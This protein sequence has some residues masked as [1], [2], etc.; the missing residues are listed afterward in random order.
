MFSVAL[1]YGRDNSLKY[2]VYMQIHFYCGNVNKAAT[3]NLLL[4][5]WLK[6]P[7]PARFFLS[8]YGY[9]Y[10]LW[11]TGEFP[12]N[13]ASG[14]LEKP[15]ALAATS[16]QGRFDIFIQKLYILVKRAVWTFSSHE[17]GWDEWHLQNPNEL[18][19]GHTAGTTGHQNDHNLY[20][21]F[22]R[23]IEVKWNP[24]RWDF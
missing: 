12:S 15:F 11:N 23:K 7:C 14:T 10:L 9:L 8:F 16:V 4:N 19:E 3:S 20:R 1:C 24:L 13:S 22:Y 6:T 5:P 18:S 21:L 2:S 17:C